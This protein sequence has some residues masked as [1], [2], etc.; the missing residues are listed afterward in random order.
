[1]DKVLDAYREQVLRWNRQ[2][3]LISRQATA[4]R[5][6]RLILQ[7]RNSWKRLAESDPGGFS[8]DT[9]L[10]YFD[11][12]SGAGFPGFIWHLL[13]ANDG[14]PIRTRLVE[15]REKRAWFLNRLDSLEGVAPLE[16]LADRWENAAATDTAAA[17][18]SPDPTHVLLSLKA[19]HLT[20][21]EVLD[22]LIPFLLPAQDYQGSIGA[23]KVLIARFYPPGQAWDDDLAQDLKI[24][25]SGEARAFPGWE[26]QGAGG[27]VLLSKSPRG[28]SLVLS[29][30]IANPS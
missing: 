11:L 24:P 20:D 19:L 30:Y 14:V 6:E 17:N 3:N 10:W 15:P 29:R 21:T 26:F 2:I 12:G 16:V 28:A 27:S 25:P 22:G 1:M 4:D 23:L 13:A 8:P 9:R 5:L 18:E 7:S